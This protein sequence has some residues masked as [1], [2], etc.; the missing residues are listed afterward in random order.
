MWVGAGMRIVVL[1]GTGLT[2]PFAVRS[3]ERLDHRVTVF[4]RGLHAADFP[5]GVRIIQAISPP[6]PPNCANPLPT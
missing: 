1:G 6:C 5:A 4:H 2:G 3:L